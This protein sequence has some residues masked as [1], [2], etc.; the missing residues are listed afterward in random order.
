MGSTSSGTW[1]W[2]SQSQ[3]FGGGRACFPP[4]PALDGTKAE[5]GL[6]RCAVSEKR[7]RSGEE[8]SGE[9]EEVLFVT[10]EYYEGGG[11]S[12]RTATGTSNNRNLQAR[13]FRIMHTWLSH[14]FAGCVTHEAYTLP[15]VTSVASSPP[16]AVPALNEQEKTAPGSRPSLLEVALTRRDGGPAAAFM[17]LASMDPELTTEVTQRSNPVALALRLYH[18]ASTW[19]RFARRPA[20]RRAGQGRGRR[21]HP[22]NA[23]L[24]AA[25]DEADARARQQR[26]EADYESALALLNTGLAVSL[27]SATFRDVTGVGD[28]MHS[29]GGQT[30]DALAVLALTDA[31]TA[32][33]T[34]ALAKRLGISVL[35]SKAAASERSGGTFADRKRGGSGTRGRGRS[36][37][38]SIV[39]DVGGGWND[40]RGSSCDGKDEVC[41]AIEEWVLRPP[42]AVKRRA[43]VA[44]L[45]Q[46]ANDL[47]TG[48]SDHGRVRGSG[49]GGGSCN[50]GGGVWNAAGTTGTDVIVL[51]LADEVREAIHRIHVA[52]FAAARH[53]PHDV[54]ALLREDL[55]RVSFGGA[56]LAGG[57]DDHSKHRGNMPLG[58]NGSVTVRTWA[59]S[60]SITTNDR[61]TAK[62][63][64]VRASQPLD[65]P[66]D[67]WETAGDVGTGND[68]L[69]MRPESDD[70]CP[71]PA[72]LSSVEAFAEF[73]RLV[74]LAE[75]MELAA[76][77]GD[78]G[79]VAQ[80]A[81]GMRNMVFYHRGLTRCERIFEGHIVC[82]LGAVVVASS[83]YEF[84]ARIP[85]T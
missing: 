35:P 72:I 34:R 24:A 9:S 78:S 49:G 83:A 32:A 53:G 17:T 69:N 51:R 70:H 55:T 36:S 47:V 48:S 2:A 33:E 66:S 8:R 85:A 3:V 64:K 31:L 62:R 28:R 82:C 25:V 76:G 5:S 56:D 18:G 42:D 11:S 52:F 6:D 61:L 50:R 75:A 4:E 16:E 54:L 71:S 63:S 29:G 60:D 59:R 38:G 22:N 57:T 79:Y 23:T 67:P 39:G 68:S 65:V 73:Y 58:W 41:S 10:E 30:G 21:L 19:R 45:G 40:E 15:Q 20:L 43:R 74:V 81:P 84:H 27:A 7:V 44:R 14:S 77:A 46:L 1:G 26:A 80:A 37:G 12:S 13:N